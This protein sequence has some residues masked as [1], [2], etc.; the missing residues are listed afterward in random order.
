[1]EIPFTVDQFYDVFRDY[2][3]VVWP[4]Q[5]LLIG[6]ALVGVVLVIKPRGWSHSAVSGILAVLWV[7]LAVVYHF[8]F[9]ARINPLAYAFSALS[10]FGAAVFVWDGLVRRRL[11]FEWS[12]SIRSWVGA[13][14]IGF[15]LVVYPVW[16][17]AAGHAYP[18]T[19]TFGLPCPTTLYTVGMLAFLVAPYPRKPHVVP[20]LWSAIGAQ[21][22]FFLGVP[23]DLSLIGAGLIG[24]VLFLRNDRNATRTRGV[25]DG[26]G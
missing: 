18:Y 6:L 8:A 19:P 10:L 26:G 21:A 4:T 20:I 13:A 25:V 5:L 22:A 24:I 11:R 12:G 23:Q 16:S 7:W 3:E 1:M 15:G 9:F 17:W 14:L 2:N